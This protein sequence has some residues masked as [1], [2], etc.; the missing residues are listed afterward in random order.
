MLM[1]FLC[2][3][4]FGVFLGTLDFGTI[5]NSDHNLSAEYS[6]FTKIMGEMNCSN[7]E[8]TVTGISE[9]GGFLKKEALWMCPDDLVIRW[10]K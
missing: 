9:Q 2:A 7:T 6:E 4:A 10:K 8:L 1:F 3:A 5:R